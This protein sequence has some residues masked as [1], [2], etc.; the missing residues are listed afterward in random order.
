MQ[1]RT[2][3]MPDPVLVTQPTTHPEKQKAIKD[4][5]LQPP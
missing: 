2:V 4:K 1:L 3:L 5:K